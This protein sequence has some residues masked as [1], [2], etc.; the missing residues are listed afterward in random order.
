MYKNIL[1]WAIVL[2]LIACGV[3]YRDQTE[4]TGTSPAVVQD[5]QHR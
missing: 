3:Y 1:V 4:R 2:I 5:Q